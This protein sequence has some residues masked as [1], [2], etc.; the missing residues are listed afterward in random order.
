MTTYKLS[1]DAN[2]CDA[3][4]QPTAA[5]QAAGQSI[6]LFNAWAVAEKYWALKPE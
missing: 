6:A 2:L 4:L 5:T 3:L 1:N